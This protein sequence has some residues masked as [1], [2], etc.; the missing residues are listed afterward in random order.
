MYHT[1]IDVLLIGS[2]SHYMPNKFSIPDAIIFPH[3]V[4]MSFRNIYIYIYIY[5]YTYICI[6]IYWIDVSVLLEN[7][8]KLIYFPY[9]H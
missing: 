4:S 6:Y 1:D 3:E 9:P 2:V 8:N 5:I 7:N